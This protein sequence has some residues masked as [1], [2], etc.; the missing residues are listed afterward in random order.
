MASFVRVVR[1]CGLPP[2]IA[3][4]VR[5]AAID[6]RTTR[7][8]GYAISQRKRKRFEQVFGWLKTID[9]LFTRSQSLRR[10]P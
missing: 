1:A 8:P 6:G 3:C 4:K 2:H 5:F 9:T 7:Q 10:W